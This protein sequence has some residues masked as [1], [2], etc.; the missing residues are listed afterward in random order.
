M[1]ASHHR[2]PREP[3]NSGPIPPMARVV[4]GV[5][6]AAVF[7]ALIWFTNAT[8]LL[9]VALGVATLA[10]HE[11]L[12]LFRA[13]GADVHAAPTFAATWAALA[14]VAFPT[15]PLELLLA[16]AL[17]VIAIWTMARLK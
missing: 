13:L 14:N 6:L 8:V 4:S 9:F 7:F 10:V 15:L 3:S 16:I 17:I 12:Q 2:L 1:A 5:M 11:Y